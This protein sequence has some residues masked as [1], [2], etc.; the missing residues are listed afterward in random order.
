MTDYN[1]RIAADTSIL[2]RLGTPEALDEITRLGF[3]HV[4]MGLAHY[5][6]HEATDEETKNLRKMLLDR[7][8][9]LAALVCIYPVSYPD[10]EIRTRGV[11]QYVRAIGRAKELGCEVIASE[12]M[13]DEENYKACADAFTRSMRELIPTLESNGVRLCFEAHPGDFTD[14]NK[15]AAD[16]IRSIGSGNVRY[17]YCSPHSFVLGEDV[18]VMIDYAADVLGYVHF[19]DSLR[20]EKT[21]FSGRYVPKVPPHQHLTPGRG[22]VDLTKMVAGLKKAGYGGCV[23]VNP[24]SMF[25]DPVR[26]L[27]DSKRALEQMIG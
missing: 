15:I 22:D 6:A 7:G 14:R 26:A 16:L 11:E 5:F 3:G 18:G 23:T 13:G 12:L 1:L 21:F 27:G 2:R 19:S 9:E 20:P 4:E 8:L 10:E 25:D 17:L 24:F